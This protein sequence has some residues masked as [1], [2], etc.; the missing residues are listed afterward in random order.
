MDYPPLRLYDIPP[1]GEVK[2]KRLKS[3]CFG[4]IVAGQDFPP[5]GMPLDITSR[6]LTGGKCSSLLFLFGAQT[7][8]GTQD[9]S[10]GGRDVPPR[11]PLVPR[12][13]SLLC[14][15]PCFRACVRPFFCSAGVILSPPQLQA[16]TL[17][18]RFAPSCPRSEYKITV[19]AFFC[20]EAEAPVCFAE[21]KTK[22]RKVAKRYCK[23]IRNPI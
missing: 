18:G 22:I 17:A 10:N 7:I 21:S 19:F 8:Q 20:M 2:G 5:A 13:S 14:S 4:W 1:F 12:V 9:A 6:R 11:R 23:A 15:A 16:L 3:F